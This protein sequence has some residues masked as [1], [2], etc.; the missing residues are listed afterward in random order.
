MC[1]TNWYLGVR[2]P[3][4]LRWF[5]VVRVFRIVVQSVPYSLTL[6][7]T[8]PLSRNGRNITA[9]IYTRI[10]FC[11]LDKLLRYGEMMHT[12]FNCQLLSVCNII[13]VF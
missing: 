6:V 13:K 2:G 1:S 3:E 10:Y 12:I 9:D 11:L 7:R 8:A 5:T 4:S